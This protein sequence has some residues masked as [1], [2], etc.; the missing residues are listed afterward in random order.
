MNGCTL[1][2]NMYKF[3]LSSSLILFSSSSFATEPLM[4]PENNSYF[5]VTGG[6]GVSQVNETDN[7]EDNRQHLRSFDIRFGQ[8][9][10][11]KWRI[12]LIHAN[13]GHPYN[14]HRDGFAVQ[15][16]YVFDAFESF[17][18]EVGTGPYLSFDTYNDANGVE[19]NEKRLGLMSTAGFVFPVDFLGENGHFKFQWNNYVMSARP[20]ANSFLF[21]VGF[22]IDNSKFQYQPNRKS[23][24][25]E[26][27]L[28]IINAKN[29]HGGPDTTVGASIDVAK[30]F[31]SN[32]ALSVG[33][34][35]E[36][37]YNGATDRQGF[38]AQVWK[39]VP[40]ASGF[41]GRL[42]IGG[43]FA[44]DKVEDKHG[45][46]LKGLFTFGINYYPEW[47][48]YDGLYLGGSITRVADRKGYED[49]ADLFRFSL[50]KKF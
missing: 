12:D 36:G 29:N 22:D 31:D 27:W 47:E 17:R 42:G 26:A 28:S 19:L 50:G 7:R 14:H 1:N 13:E 3:L 24:F 45:Y 43:Y 8:H 35:Y 16:A 25:N 32:I 39:V 11:P 23:F 10:S 15:A 40:L 18:L 9:F 34:I 6:S 4:K 2:Y 46:D 33:Y 41:E 37:G 20:N 21:G 38:S 30:R 5:S 48:G 49:D 44:N